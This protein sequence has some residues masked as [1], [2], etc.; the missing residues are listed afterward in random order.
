MFS[1]QESNGKLNCTEYYHLL[2]TVQERIN[3][4]NFY[5]DRGFLKS[6]RREPAPSRVFF[7]LH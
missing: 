6:M 7:L 2:W 5:R 4:E 3:N 1:L